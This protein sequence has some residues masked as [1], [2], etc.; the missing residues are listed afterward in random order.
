L[1]PSRSALLTRGRRGLRRRV[2][3]P[4]LPG[5]AGFPAK[6]FHNTFGDL[7]L[8]ELTTQV[9]SF[10]IEALDPFGNPLFLLA[11]QP[12]HLLISPLCQ[13]RAHPQRADISNEQKISLSK[14]TRSAQIAIRT[15]F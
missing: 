2:C 13:V 7:Q 15:D 12:R 8:I 10:G 4:P 5:C 9:F 6:S 1:V 14:E 11:H 3:S